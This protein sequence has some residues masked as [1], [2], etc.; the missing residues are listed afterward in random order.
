[1]GAIPH[2]E[3]CYICALHGVTT[4]YQQNVQKLPYMEVFKHANRSIIIVVIL[5]T[6]IIRCTILWS[7]EF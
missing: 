3:Q 7:M 6:L 5:A 4:S 1:M 2:L